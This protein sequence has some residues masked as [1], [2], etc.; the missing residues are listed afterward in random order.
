M[1]SDDDRQ[2]KTKAEQG[3]ALNTCPAASS[4]CYDYSTFNPQSKSRPQ[5]GCLRIKR[6]VRKKEH[7]E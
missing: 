7:E 3:T 5:Q 6:S 2:N 1:L 4:I